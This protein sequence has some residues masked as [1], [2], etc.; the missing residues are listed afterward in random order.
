M[1]WGGEGV[2]VS[3]IECPKVKDIDPSQLQ[4]NNMYRIET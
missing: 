1:E 3:S 4:V 2:G